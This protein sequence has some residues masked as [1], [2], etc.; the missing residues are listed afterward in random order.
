[1]SKTGRQY[2]ASW[3]LWSS[4]L[5]TILTLGWPPSP[6]KPQTIDWWRER[7][8]TAL[9][10]LAVILGAVAYIPGMLLAVSEGRVLISILD[11]VALIFLASLF[12]TQK[13][14][15]QIKAIFLVASGLLL[16][17][18]L[19]IMVGFY[20]AGY[21]WLFSGCLL[22]GV[23][24]GFPAMAIVLG[25]SIAA[26]IGVGFAMGQNLFWWGN[27]E[28]AAEK[29]TVVTS[30]FFF[31]V[32]MLTSGVSI[33][34]R[35]L[36]TSLAK[37]VKARESLEVER[38]SLKHINDELIDQIERR[39]RAE[40]ALGHSE[41]K[42]HE[43]V[44]SIFDA[45]YTHDLDGRILSIN[46]IAANALGYNPNQVVGKRLKNYLT[47]KSYADTINQYLPRLKSLGQDMG[48]VEVLAVDGQ[49]HFFEYRSSLVQ[50]ETGLPYISG[51]ARDST[52]RLESQ[53]KLEKLQEQL[54]QSRK[55]EALGTLAGGIA[56]D[57]NNILSAIIG[58]TEMSLDNT[59]EEGQ[60]ENA[61]FLNKVIE[62]ANRARELVRQI[63]TFSRRR[64][65]EKVP[66]RL[67]P[68]VEEGLSMLR[69]IIPANVNIQADFLVQ[70]AVIDCDATQIQQ[71]LMNLCTNAAHA[72]EETGGNLTIS[73][74]EVQLSKTDAAAENGLAQG[75]YAQIMIQDQGAGISKDISDRIFDPFFS[76]KP[77]KKGSGMGLAVVHGIVRDHGGKIEFASSPEGTTFEVLLPISQSAEA[78]E[79]K[80]PTTLPRGSERIVFIDD[81][82][83]LVDIAKN[84]LSKLG[85]QVK[86]FTN[87]T[88]ALGSIK[89]DPAGVD[90]VITDQTMPSMTGIQV[91]EQVKNLRSDLPVLLCT[92]FSNTVSN[93]KLSQSGV[94]QL[95]MKPISRSRLAQTIR[96]LLDKIQ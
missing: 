90:L 74:D 69:A 33:L 50:P 11:T 86:G 36:Q 14:S 32:A 21:L 2:K 95:L 8:V 61:K 62:S 9:L 27:V 60:T 70:E 92:G 94:D 51:L 18:T 24:W 85:Y 40:N 87:P 93:E 72:M 1:M 42:Y 55:M 46:T 76:T 83:P 16:G 29:W 54:N 5:K 81:E 43:L 25:L 49:V 48:T 41:Q 35:G 19:L 10:A 78:V 64:I 30:N 12:F 15:Y 39:Q 91:A 52:Q 3:R 79:N 84:A 4:Q 22:A 23:I 75:A 68:L 45:I 47:R 58:Y 34:I 17:V 66:K 77:E 88:Q 73:I 53:Q 28:N 56:H 82:E 6:D 13:I 65:G 7:I 57:F 71:L 67:Q 63:L 96:S 31:L 59:T 44:E 89:S 20:G 38:A 80:T 26:L 37:E